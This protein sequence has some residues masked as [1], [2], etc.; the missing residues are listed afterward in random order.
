LFSA[1]L[2]LEPYRAGCLFPHSREFAAY[3]GELSSFSQEL[4]DIESLIQYA[5]WSV[6]GGAA[7]VE[8]RPFPGASFFAD[9][10]AERQFYDAH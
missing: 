3:S 2:S 10:G 6:R 7:K 5:E 4:K 1:D 8:S 9:S